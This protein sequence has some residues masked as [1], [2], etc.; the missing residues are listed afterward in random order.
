MSA[1][2]ALER[3]LDRIDRIDRNNRYGRRAGSV[4]D[5]S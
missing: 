5:R 1:K 4:S 3:L 2:I